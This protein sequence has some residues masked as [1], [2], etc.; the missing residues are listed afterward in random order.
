MSCI[1]ELLCKRINWAILEHEEGNEI[2][3]TFWNMK[4]FHCKV[5]FMSPSEK[6]KCAGEYSSRSEFYGNFQS[7]P[8]GD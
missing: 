3:L 4:I 1:N 8:H 6:L 7:Q 5:T 2:L